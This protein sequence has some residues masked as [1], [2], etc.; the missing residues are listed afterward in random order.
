VLD[1]SESAELARQTLLGSNPRPASA[2]T[3]PDASTPPA[4][5]VLRT[6][7]VRVVRSLA[8]WIGLSGLLSLAVATLTSVSYFTGGGQIAHVVVG[9][10]AGAS[11][12]WLAGAAFNLHRLSYRA[13]QPRRR[14]IRAFSLLRSALLLKALLVFAATVI[15]CLA[16]SIAGS[17][18][19]LL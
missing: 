2:A 10:L 11:G 13:P 18:L 8:R 4:Y 5:L 9:I 15:G 7:E 19:L 16:F 14:L 6:A 12:L 3:P 1:P 17:L